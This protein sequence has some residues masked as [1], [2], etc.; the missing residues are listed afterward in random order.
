MLSKLDYHGFEEYLISERESVGLLWFQY[1]FKF[2]N[3]YGASVVKNLDSY[4]VKD[5]L[6]ELA[7]LR[8]D[9]DDFELC[10]DTP[11]TDDV[12]GCLTDSGVRSLLQQ[13]KEL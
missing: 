8:F 2:D 3:E 5:D 1:H 12:V 7:V 13:I 10:Y 6:F 9:G 4:G 11:I